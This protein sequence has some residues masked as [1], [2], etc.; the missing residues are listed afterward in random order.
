LEVK[1]EQGVVEMTMEHFWR[2]KG[3]CDGRLLTLLEVATLFLLKPRKME[4]K[5]KGVETYNFLKVLF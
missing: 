2:Q 4:R 3:S 1:R 5:R